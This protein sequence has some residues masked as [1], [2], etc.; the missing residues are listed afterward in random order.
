MAVGT[1][2]PAVAPPEGISALCRHSNPCLDLQAVA[3]CITAL[4]SGTAE[5]GTNQPL[6]VSA[7]TRSSFLLASLERLMRPFQAVPRQPA[8]TVHFC[9]SNQRATVTIV[10]MP[11]IMLKGKVTASD[12]VSGSPTFTFGRASRTA[13]GA[14]M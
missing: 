2:A 7:L 14:A 13:A 11:S 12:I 6:H 10:G 5:R 1:N 9:Y 8:G 4:A 3:L